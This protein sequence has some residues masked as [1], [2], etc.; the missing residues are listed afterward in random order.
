MKP[1]LAIDAGASNLKVALFE[2]QEN[3]TLILAH[4]EVV[5]LELR[6]L[7]SDRTD[8]LKEKL[9]ELFDQTNSAEGNA[10][11]MRSA[12]SVLRS[13]WTPAVEGSLDKFTV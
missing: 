2:P 13:S 8:L 9:Q 4:Y 7:E 5:S 10:I 6:G 3:G 1:F 12:F 11:Y